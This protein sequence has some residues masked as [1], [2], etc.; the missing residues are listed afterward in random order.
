VSTTATII[1]SHQRPAEVAEM[2]GWWASYADLDSILVV[3]GGRRA[4]FEDLRHPHKA[5]VDDPRFVTPEHQ[6]NK[7]SHGP[8]L[9][10]AARWLASRCFEHVLYAEYD[11]VPVAPDLISL[12][13][14]RLDEE[15]ADLLAMHLR[16]IDATSYP[17]FLYH[18]HD[19]AFMEFWRRVSVREDKGVVLSMLGAG[20]FWRRRCF[21]AVARTEESVPAYT[22]LFVPT[23]AHHLGFRVRGLPDQSR[24][25]T[26]QGERGGELQTAAA[27]GAWTVHPVKTL[28]SGSADRR[29]AL[30]DRLA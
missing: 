13:E 30:R 4:D 1:L 5:F 16:R 9:R 10:A 19:R 24:W 26:P 17:H 6:R 7:Q 21:D 25:N 29:S 3:H 11:Q 20:S 12:Y 14:R 27:S 22:E 23:L 8:V 15:G 18:V 2:L 28:W